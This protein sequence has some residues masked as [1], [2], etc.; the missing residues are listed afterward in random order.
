MARTL[1]Q[2]KI[3]KAIRDAV[4]AGDPQDDDVLAAGHMVR[5]HPR[6]R[7]LSD[8]PLTPVPAPLWLL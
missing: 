2:K 6:L 4:S 1:V 7:R 8:Y 3:R 5:T